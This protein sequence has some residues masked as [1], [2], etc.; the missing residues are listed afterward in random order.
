MSFRGWPEEAIEFFEGLEADNSKA[1]W[2]QNKETYERCVRAPMVELVDELSGRF[3]EA[4][5]FRPY[6]DIRFSKDKSPYKT[7]VAA[8]VG[9]SGYVTLSADGLGVGAGLYMMAPD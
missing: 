4:K 2:T 5:I 7:N 6:R 1:Y 9:S 8:A 3:G